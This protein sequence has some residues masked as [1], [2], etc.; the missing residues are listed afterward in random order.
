[1]AGFDVKESELK[2]VKDKI[3]KNKENYF[4]VKADLRSEEN[5]VKAIEWTRKNVGPIHVLINNAGVLCQEPLM[6][7]K[8]K[9]WKDTFAVNVIGLCT[10]TREAMKD[11]LKHKINGHV[12][13]VCS[14][15]GHYVPYGV[16]GWSV[17]P[18]TKHAVTALTETMR[19]ELNLL[20]KNIKIGVS[21]YCKIK[22]RVLL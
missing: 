9:G 12:I 19:Q 11:M 8:T 15:T 21:S 4:P 17:Y 5:T 20:D 6:T 2:M 3:K 22:A 10:C 13:H 7:G 16:P 14:I 1:M 18:A